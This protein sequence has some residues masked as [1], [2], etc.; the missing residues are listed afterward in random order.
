MKSFLLSKTVNKN[1]ICKQNVNRE[2]KTESSEIKILKEFGIANNSIIDLDYDCI[3]SLLALITSENDLKIF[4]KG[5]LEIT[6]KIPKTVKKVKFVKGIY[7]V[8]ICDEDISTIYTISVFSLKIISETELKTIVTVCETYPGCEFI[9]LGMNDGSILF[10]DV[11]R[12]CMS[13]YIIKDLQK[14]CLNLEN[15]E[16]ISIGWC[17]SDTDIILITFFNCAFKYSLKE[18]CVKL[19][20]VLSFK[21]DT[22]GY[23]KYLKANRKIKNETNDNGLYSPKIINSQLHPN[24][25][26][27]LTLHEHGIITFWDFNSGILIE[28]RTILE[29]NLQKKFDSVKLKFNDD[30]ITDVKWISKS[31]AEKTQILV[32]G[33]FD[34]VKNA[35]IV[36]DLGTSLI[37]SLSSYEK[38]ESFYSNPSNGMKSIFFTLEESFSCS[39]KHE[40]IDKIFT[41]NMKNGYEYDNMKNDKLFLI[42]H[43]NL[44][45]IYFLNYL[46]KNTDGLNDNLNV[47]LPLSLNFIHP[48]IQFSTLILVNKI[49]WNFF[50]SSYEKKRNIYYFL[51][52]GILKEEYQSFKP[53]TDASKYYY[54]FLTVHNKSLIRFFNLSHNINENFDCVE[55]NINDFFLL[56]DNT[57]FEIESVSC[58]FRNYQMIVLLKN[59]NILVLS[60]DLEKKGHNRNDNNEV[61][62]SD[63]K[64]I[65]D[66]Q[67]PKF[68]ELIH[69]IKHKFLDFFLPVALLKL[70]TNEKVFCFKLCDFGFFGVSYKSGRIIICDIRHDCTI[71]H[72]EKSISDYLNIKKKIYATNFEFTII[73]HCKDNF[74]SIILV[75]GTNYQDIFL[76][77]KIIP[78]DNKKFKLIF[79]NSKI[80]KSFNYQKK[81]YGFNQI[82]PIEKQTNKPLISNIKTFNLLSESVLI[83]GYFVIISDKSLKIIDLPNNIISNKTISDEILEGSIVE[84]KSEYYL[85]C[86]LKSGF[87]SFFS[88]P[89]FVEKLKLKVSD[90]IEKDL[91]YSFNSNVHKNFNYLNGNRI[92]FK[93]SCSE[94]KMISFN[95]NDSCHLSILSEKDYDFF[96]RE[97]KITQNSL[98]N[99]NWFIK[100]NSNFNQLSLVLFSNG[101]K[102]NF[103]KEFNLINS[104]NDDHVRPK[105]KSKNIKNPINNNSDS[106]LNIDKVQNIIKDSFS[107]T[108]DTISKSLSNQKKNVFKSV[109]KSKLGF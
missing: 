27:L 26:H 18:K 10:Y 94:F 79:C 39:P 98:L 2:I 84:Y 61:N 41:I 31:N 34:G 106:N 67:V 43:S 52:G 78:I 47:V 33:S 103:R 46:F 70:N 1:N 68:V 97:N 85:S 56:K 4:A 16:V 36:F 24:G 92:L 21:N 42:L 49:K 13:N 5:S 17:A 15:T 96:N 37:Y 87:L 73:K 48:K 19:F 32:V 74:S 107:S 54:I 93:K 108:I 77:F 14:E 62:F 86:L 9:I 35:L 89:N 82:I 101:R 90:D 63:L 12:D 100:K 105:I 75:I 64:K 22:R 6:I 60:S 83:L 38:Q 109:L 53:I 50:F 55:I 65:E 80:I 102:K 59:Q 69:S 20:F 29:I 76:N 99:T 23:Q 57:F 45:T 72:D 7:I 28:S 3:Q 11:D 8:V 95:S 91:S 104:N 66:D 30:I 71:I 44:K 40:I 81:S 88:I 58:S 25:S 51:K